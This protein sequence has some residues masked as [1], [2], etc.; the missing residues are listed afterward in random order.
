MF[1]VCTKVCHGE[2]AFTSFRMN[3]RG[4]RITEECF[5]C[6]DVF[7]IAWASH[8]L[9]GKHKL[10]FWGTMIK[11]LV[12]HSCGNIKLRRKMQVIRNIFCSLIVFTLIATNSAFGVSGNYDN[13]SS[14]SL[15]NRPISHEN[16]DMGQ[17]RAIMQ[18]LM[19]TGDGRALS[20]ED[21]AEK[22]RQY[23]EEHPGIPQFRFNEPKVYGDNICVVCLAADQDSGA[24]N[25]YYVEFPLSDLEETGIRDISLN[26]YPARKW[27]GAL[28]ELN[29]AENPGELLNIE[30][31][32]DLPEELLRFFSRAEIEKRGHIIGVPKE[33]KPQAERVGLTPKGVKILTDNGVKVIVEKGLGVRG[34]K[35]IFSDEDYRAVGAE[36][37]DT[38][39]EV[40]RRATIIKKVKEP[41][42]DEIIYLRDDLF[43]FTYLHLAS[44]E[45]E[46]LTDDMI[47][48]GITGIAYETIKLERDGKIL[49]P[50]LKPMSEVAGDLGGYFAIPY[51][52]N[53]IDSSDAGEEVLLD[54]EGRILM[55]KIRDNY[56]ENDGVPELKGSGVLKGKE[57]VVLGGGVS[58]EKMAL[59]LLE[60]G[61]SV[62]ITDINP[63]R[64]DELKNIFAE[65]GDR[66]TCMQVNRDINDPTPELMA[67]YSTADILGGCILIPGQTAPQ[68][69]ADL[70][71][72]ISAI[73]KKV[74]VDIALDQGGNFPFSKSKSHEHPVFRDEY[75]NRRYCVPNMP[76][77]AGRIASIK[78]E[79]S[80]IAYTL[81]LC[82]GFEKAIDIFPEL[83]GGLN[84][85]GGEIINAE[86]VKAYPLKPHSTKMLDSLK[87]NN[88]LKKELSVLAGEVGLDL[89]TKL[90]SRYV[91]ISPEDFFRGN[92]EEYESQKTRFSDRLDLLRIRSK[93]GLT[94]D[95]YVDMV[96]SEAKR[97]PGR[98][99]ALVPQGID[100]NNVGRLLKENVRFVRMDFNSFKTVEYKYPSAARKESMYDDTVATMQL[101]RHIK[102]EDIVKKDTSKTF[103][104][105]SYYVRND[106][107]LDD[108]ISLENYF[109][110]IVSEEE[111]SIPDLLKAYLKNKLCEKFD[112]L[113]DHE[114]L[115]KAL[116]F[117]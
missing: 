117:A 114:E 77:A 58:G 66:V 44:P 70:L 35:I 45:S 30:E 32:F 36:L 8:T 76:D 34:D 20:M 105:L 68:M 1:P 50:V 22:F 92:N 98:A 80:N 113:K 27:D 94:I 52:L 75:G 5:D 96:I 31:E 4:V 90:E 46:G 10:T 106:F 67:K 85:H 24:K 57:A 72:D 37:V 63:R 84:V 18:L 3:G 43:V 26:I 74:I 28:A 95:G 64:L 49:T 79:R 12:F 6:G 107:S 2:R 73:K 15:I 53:G 16:D 9:L 41:L 71:G 33:I 97:Y 7:L 42:P 54:N 88:K 116:I 81:A 13:L 51:L 89:P 60:C 102:A 108:D 91:L 56:T 21:L 87:E 40:W 11:I 111:S 103:R 109:N 55:D 62:S 99:V 48:S 82:M 17:I 100:E 78:L 38:A 69:S 83:E 47:A 86:V 93:K 110:A 59:R 23:A 101:V 65:Y 61:A 29:L 115:S 104:L 25:K 112:A 14:G 39:E 19:T